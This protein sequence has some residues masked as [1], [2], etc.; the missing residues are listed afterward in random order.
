MKTKLI[1]GLALVLLGVLILSKFMFNTQ[2]RNENT[3]IMLNVPPR[4]APGDPILGRQNA[5][6]K[7]VNRLARF[8]VADRIR[9]TLGRWVAQG[10]TPLLEPQSICLRVRRMTFVLQSKPKQDR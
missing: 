2:P 7:Y 6:A 10:P 9:K 5:A 4:M 3:E 8:K 1:T